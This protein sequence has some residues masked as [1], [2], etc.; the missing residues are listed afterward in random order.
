MSHGNGPNGWRGGRSHTIRGNTVDGANHIG[1]DTYGSSTMIEENVVTDVGLIVNLNRSGMGCDL[2][3][4]GQCTEDGAGIRLKLDPGSAA[5][6]AHDLTVRHN[7]LARIGMN[8]IDSF[9]ESAPAPEVFAHFGLDAEH[10]VTAAE[11]AIA[12]AS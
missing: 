8:G 4:V 7:R 12:A 6:T 11:R 5:W 10:V 1:I 3:A 9:G 2:T